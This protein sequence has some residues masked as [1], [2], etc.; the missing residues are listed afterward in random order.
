[1]SINVGRAWRGRD[2]AL[3]VCDGW[4]GGKEPRGRRVVNIADCL[5]WMRRGHG[6]QASVTF[7]V[8]FGSLANYTS[9]LIHRNFVIFDS[10]NG[11]YAAISYFFYKQ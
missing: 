5:A 3:G 11:K 9:N 7:T 4:G 2:G 1:M 8:G 10:C 6:H